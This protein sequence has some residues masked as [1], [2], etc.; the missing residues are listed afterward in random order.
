MT[1]A[2]WMSDTKRRISENGGDGVTRSVHELYVG[3]LRR[4]DRFHNFG[5]PIYERDWDLLVVLD[6]CRADLMAEVAD[7]YD[8]VDTERTTSLAGGSKRWM[9]RNFVENPNSK[10]RN[11]VYVTGNPFSDEMLSHQPFRNMEEVW[12]YAWDEE[13]NTV[14][15][16]AVTDVTVQQARKYDPDSLIAHYMQPHHP[17]V[18]TPLDSG[19]NRHDLK[20]PDRPVWDKLRDGEI[21]PQAA[22]DAYRENLQYVLDDVELLLANVDADR[23]I[24]TA[25]HG[26]AF[27]E[28]GMWGHGDIPLSAVRDV[29]WCVTT[30]TD[31][32][33]HDPDIVP[34]RDEVAVSDKL[35]DLGYL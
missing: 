12:K 5:V 3:A 35:R 10:I 14:P 4:V 16:R 21:D 8:F 32:G 11:T 1:F 19:M 23:A 6:A 30:A 13:L 27:G 24:I 31:T 15:A 28:W 18:P 34:E 33:E 20:N 26:N 9:K 17:F 2:E 22:W 7:E 29:P 25:D